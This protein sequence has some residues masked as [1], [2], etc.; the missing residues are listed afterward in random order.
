MKILTLFILIYSTF[1]HGQVTDGLFMLGLNSEKEIVKIQSTN[2][3]VTLKIVSD[4]G[5][6]MMALKV[7]ADVIKYSKENVPKI[8]CTGVGEIKDGIYKS[9]KIRQCKDMRSGELLYKAF[10]KS[11]EEG[12]AEFEAINENLLLEDTSFEL[13]KNITDTDRTLIKQSP[14]FIKKTD[15]TQ[16]PKSTPL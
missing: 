4:S 2:P 3:L 12:I 8:L 14:I 9:E 1:G 5:M 16:V 11:I 7:L 15:E 6:E 10:D 13:L